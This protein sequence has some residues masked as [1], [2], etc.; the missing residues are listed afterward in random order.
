M[1]YKEMGF[2]GHRSKSKNYVP[3]TESN[4]VGGTTKW[5]MSESFKWLRER[6]DTV[7][8]ML[9]NNLLS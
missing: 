1:I 2:L 7:E 9:Y 4:M 6:E 3:G 5:S 8:E